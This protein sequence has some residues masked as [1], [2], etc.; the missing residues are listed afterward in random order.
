[1]K[2][3]KYNVQDLFVNRYVG[4]I[5]IPEIQR[6]Y[7]WQPDQVEGLLGSIFSDY[8]RYSTATVELSCGDPE[9]EQAFSDFI[10]KRKY[11]SNIGFIYAYHDQQFEGKY[12]LID[13]Q[14]RLTTIFLLLLNLACRDTAVKEKFSKNYFYGDVPK[15]DYRIRESS[16][17]FL[18]N[19]IDF[20][21]GGNPITELEKQRWL[22]SRY[23][24]DATTASLI[25]NYR[26][27]EDYINNSGIEPA[28][29][30]N[31][32]VELVEFWYFDTNVSEQGE[33][34]YIYMNAR[35]EQV[36]NNENVKA[37]LLGRLAST[38]QK[39]EYGKIWEDWQDFFWIKKD[40]NP[41]A[42]AGFNEFLSCIAGLENYL[43]HQDKI[44]FYTQ[45]DFL[46]SEGLK[47]SDILDIVNLIT[48]E[49][50][51]SFVEFI[52]LNATHFS[53]KYPYSGWIEKAI[54]LLWTILNDPAKTN[55]LA[56][57]SDPNRG[58]EQ[59]RMVYLWS[60]FHFF[61]R[62]T[63]NSE[64]DVDTVFRVLRLYY[65]RYHN[66][67]RAVSGIKATVD[68]ILT[69]GL[70]QLKANTEESKKH[71]YLEGLPE[72]NL[73]DC[74]SEIWHI[75]D[76]KLNLEGR[77]VGNTNISHLIDLNN[78]V[79]LDDLTLVRE[80][81]YEIFPRRRREKKDSLVQSILLYF[82]E[83]WQRVTPHY[84][85][86]YKFDDWPKIIR[87]LPA[88][89]NKT[90]SAF[91]SEFLLFKGSL[92]KFLEKKQKQKIT[93][94]KCTSLREMLLFYNQYL[95][96]DMWSQGNYIVRSQGQGCSLPNWKAKDSIFGTS[97]ILYNTKGDLKGGNPQILFKRLPKEVRTANKS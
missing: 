64:P 4:Q 88:G 85:E 70:W 24:T 13:G 65:V 91:F 31:Y 32:I 52:E 83:Y 76:H 53:S 20:L 78:S 34:L 37:E 86:N 56:D 61:A 35:G 15:I 44:P 11:A 81:F 45:D 40:N 16:H 26:F 8:E 17:D 49:K 6:D 48:I 71:A 82:G 75:E 92:E 80:K 67:D 47:V 59:N 46:R 60:M 21:I 7:V 96:S 73:L 30:Y 94:A 87:N 9:L 10:V 50:Y 42:D 55:W 25:K 19:F 43:R 68:N 84:Y 72:D 89:P 39:N 58:R 77:D 38:A 41:N 51:Y 57:F 93:V 66:Y 1:M 33:E 28:K 97:H 3:G 63:E 95:G 18:Y 90:F 74:E 62:H 29:L 14:Q 79:T 5:I 54:K 22:Y 27:I 23:S 69:N 12:F 2:A 36:Q